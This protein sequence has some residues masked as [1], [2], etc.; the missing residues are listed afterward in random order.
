MTPSPYTPA[1]PDWAAP[2]AC[3]YRFAVDGPYREYDARRLIERAAVAVRAD[4]VG[5]RDDVDNILQAGDAAFEWT[6]TCGV[7]LVTFYRRD[8]LSA[9]AAGLPPEVRFAVATDNFDPDLDGLAPKPGINF[10]IRNSG[11]ETVN[12]HRFPGRRRGRGTVRWVPAATPYGLPALLCHRLAVSSDY[13]AAERLMNED[14]DAWRA[15]HDAGRVES[16]V[17]DHVTKAM[18]R[19]AENW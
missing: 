3:L 5:L 13:A 18:V 12:V 14:P 6:G 17:I 11:Y 10:T 1:E 15:A 19:W 16:S 2:G 7:L 4:R 8:G 9:L